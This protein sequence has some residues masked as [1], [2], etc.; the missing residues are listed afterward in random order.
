M[1]AQFHV[2]RNL[3]R[4]VVRHVVVPII[5][6]METMV[7][8]KSLAVAERA[9]FEQLR[10]RALLIDVQRHF[11]FRTVYP[12]LIARPDH[13]L[14]IDAN[15]IAVVAD[16]AEILDCL[17]R[18]AAKS[19]RN[20]EVLVECDTGAGRNGVQT[21]QDTLLLAQKIQSYPNLSIGGV[22]TYPPSFKRHTVAA[23]IA[24]AFAPMAAACAG[25][26]I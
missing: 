23:F 7:I 17:S 22:M 12:G 20:L 2:L 18:A 10:R 1:Q 25:E 14:A 15:R 5:V 9:I 13:A 24:E 11:F 16:N 4:E 19:G 3:D 21:P 6:L 26:T 8:A